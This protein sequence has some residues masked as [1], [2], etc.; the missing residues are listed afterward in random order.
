M[1]D[2]RPEQHPTLL[3]LTSSALLLPGYQHA[4]ADAAPEVAELGIR[5]SNYEEDDTRSSKTFGGSSERYDID[6]AQFHLLAPVS[7]HWSVALDVSY[8]D[9]SGASPWFV[10]ES[11]EGEPKVFMSGASIEDSR[12]GVS[13][14]TR[15]YYDRGNAGFNYTRSEEN[16]YESDAIGLDASFNSEDSLTTYSGA[17]SASADEI[18]PTQGAVPTNTLKDEKDIRSAWI[19]VSRIVSKRAIVR[20]G[21]GYTYREGFLTDPYKLNDRR[22]DQRRE[23]AASTGYRHYFVNQRAAL[24]ADYRYFDDDWGI[25]SHTIDLGWHQNLGA[26][27]Q[28]IPF[29]RYYTQDEA[30]FFDNRTDFSARYYADDYRLSAFG[31]IT[32]GLRFNYSLDQWR[33]NLAGERYRS[34]ESWG[35]YSGDESPALV[36]YWRFSIGLDYSFD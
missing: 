33:V 10:G 17:I 7:D 21:L 4:Q 30:D 13:V 16:D 24:H 9:M 35:I 36:Q 26:N 31:A 11:V 15:Y 34:K 29:L 5:Y 2:K 1:A 20:F 28:L 32:A 8:E 22:P 14:T 12:T 3:A 19:G 6:V 18:E 27:A 23:W 25:R